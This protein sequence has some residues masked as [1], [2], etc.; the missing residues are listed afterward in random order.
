DDPDLDAVFAA[1]DLMAIGAMHALRQA[2]RRIPDDVAV[3]GYDDIEAARYTDP[4]LTTIHNPH[5]EQAAAMVRLLLG[6]LEGGSADP[7]IVSTELV[8]RT[9]S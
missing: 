9:S 2:G 8:V 7:S 1:N 4:P 5:A 6:L 3:V